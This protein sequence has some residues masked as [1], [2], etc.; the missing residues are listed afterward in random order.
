MTLVDAIQ[1]L[2]IDKRL[3]DYNL[4]NGVLSQEEWDQYVRSLE[5]VKDRSEGID[6]DREDRD[7]S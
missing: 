5:D 7:P 1:K 2:K 6:I 4:K 3:L